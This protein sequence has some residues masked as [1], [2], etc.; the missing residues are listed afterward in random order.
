MI[1]NHT[2]HASRTRA[3]AVLLSAEGYP[4]KKLAEI[5]DVCRQTAS[6]WLHSWKDY[7]ICGLLDEPRSGRPCKLTIEQKIDAVGMVKET[8]R[9]LK[10][11]LQKLFEEFDLKLS[12]STLKRVCREARLGWKRVR[13]SLKSKR[14]VELFEK[15]RLELAL[16]EMDARGDL[17]DLR[18]FDEAGFTLEPCIPYAWQTIGT[19]IEV[20]CSK[21]KRLNVLGLLG[22]DCSFQ[23]WVFEDG[24][25]TSSI[26][27]EF[28]D[29]LAS[30]L[31]R[32]MAVVID[33]APIHTSD[34]FTENIED[35]AKKG[36]II[37][38]IPPYSPELNLI[39]ILWR[40]TKYEWMPFSAYQ[41]F[42]NLR[43]SLYEILANFGSLY[44][45]KFS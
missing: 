20:P 25:I 31:K 14:D 44:T 22:K 36:L 19:H 9:S 8:P 10:T 34:E 26:V 13:R 24:N 42:Q 18:Y 37:V 23:S 5:F 2:C 17:I 45:I 33:N 35:W 43:E 32:P 38:Q 39:E 30:S 28:F 6:T 40:K 41:S 21:S 7:G 29:R 15:S 3:H 4:L 12:C 16:L 11:V 1:R 27:V